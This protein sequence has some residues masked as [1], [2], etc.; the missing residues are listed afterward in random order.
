M[1][2]PK[3][4]L[5]TFLATTSSASVL[6]WRRQDIPQCALDCRASTDLGGCDPE[7]S[8]CLCNDEDFV[9]KVKECI[10]E[11][12]SAD[13]VETAMEIIAAQCSDV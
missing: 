2:F 11:T 12:C 10:N 6:M 7:D 5:L 13:D 4:L 1:Y 3:I 9:T 8:Q